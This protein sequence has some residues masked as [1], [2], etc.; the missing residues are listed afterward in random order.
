MATFTFD[1]DAYEATHGHKPRG[2]GGWVFGLKP[3]A[4][5]RK[6]EAVFTPALT[7]AEAKRWFATEMARRGTTGSTAYVLA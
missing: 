4:S 5:V 7:Y 3:D 2:R 1:T 6:G